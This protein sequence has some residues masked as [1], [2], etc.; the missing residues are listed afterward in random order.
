MNYESEQIEF[1]ENVTSDIS[2]EVIAFANT[3]GGLITIGVDDRGNAIGLTDI[4]ES[5]TRLTNIIRDT[6]LPDIT[7]FV[8][9]KLND[10]KTID[11]TIN[12]GTAKPYFLKKHG[13]KPS[14][15]YVRQGTS[16]APATWEQIR[17][18]IKLTEDGS[19]EGSVSLI[20]DLTFEAAQAEF[21][22][23]GVPF[24]TDKY[25]SLGL[26]DSGKKLYKN[27]ALLLSDQ[28]EHTIKVAVFADSANTIFADRREFTGSLFKQL[29]DVY[30]YLNL[31]NHTASV[32]LGLDRV[33]SVDYPPESIR[34]ALLNALIHRDYSYSGSIIININA[35][36]MEFISL[37]GL[38]PGLSKNDILSGISLPRNEKLAAIFFRLKHVE[39]YGTGIRRIFKQY[40]TCLKKPGIFVTENTFKIKLPN[41][42]YFLQ[43]EASSY[44]VHTER[45]I[46]PV[47]LTKQMKTVID[48]LEKNDSLNENE[49][50]ELLGLKRTRSYLIAKQ[51][52]DLGLVDVTGRGKNKRYTLLSPNNKL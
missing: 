35:E 27:L 51:L 17:Q 12:E 2:K 48:Y 52:I 8:H 25:V 23:R 50:M 16:S 47:K 30:D 41:M 22:K 45:T 19:F 37:G 13:I 7:M 10:N 14:G 34:E 24:S 44:S 9:Y 49:L 4:D 6:I 42:N 18:L 11:V 33:D 3:N 40:H 15:I 39:A 5:Y 20:Q 32:I 1:K 46:L 43:E 38:L 26:F 36:M 31:N 28:C 21:A 29:H